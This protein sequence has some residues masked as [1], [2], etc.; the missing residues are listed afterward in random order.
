MTTK[1]PVLYTEHDLD[2]D[3]NVSSTVLSLQHNH[4]WI[5]IKVEAGV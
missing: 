2:I 5:S 1:S 4:I 3:I